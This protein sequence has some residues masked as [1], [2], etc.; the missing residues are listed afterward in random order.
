[1]SADV[2]RGKLE[3]LKKSCMEGKIEETNT[4]VSELQ[5]ATCDE[6]AD[7]GLERILRSLKSYDYEAAMEQID[8]LAGYL[9]EKKE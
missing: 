9:Q 3:H 2:L 6:K 1:M 4:A 8:E 5:L 7:E